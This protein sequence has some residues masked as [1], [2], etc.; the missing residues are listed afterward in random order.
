MQAKT[1]RQLRMQAFAD[2]H[3]IKC[4]KCRSSFNDWAKTG[5]TNRRPWGICIQCVRK[6]PAK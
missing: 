1:E 6:K 5:I 3:G 2:Q 4:F